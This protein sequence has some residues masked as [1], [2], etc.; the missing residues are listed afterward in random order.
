VKPSISM[1]NIGFNIYYW[2]QKE[3][4]HLLKNGLA[5]WAD[6]ASRRGLLQRLWYCPFDARSPHVFAIFAAPHARRD[7][8]KSFLEDR[9]RKFIDRTPSRVDLPEQE[10]SERHRR[11]RGVTMNCADREPGPALNNSF[12]IF[13][14]GPA[15]YPFWLNK[16]VGNAAELWEHLHLV[17][18]WCLQRA[19][20]D[21]SRAAIQWLA[22]VDRSL[23]RHQV[24][25]VDYWRYHAGSL[26]LGLE[27]SLKKQ[28]TFAGEFLQRA[29]SEKNRQVFSTTWNESDNDPPLDVDALIRLVF[30]QPDSTPDQKF[31]VLRSINHF[32]LLQLG[33]IVLHEIPIVLYAWQRNL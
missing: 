22:A 31:A 28:Q 10:V 29:V 32:T 26:L 8:L 5:L 15:D 12:T 18:S 33:Q 25:R 11:C 14:H 30:S 13:E 27:E 24:P 9:I 6:E 4:Q 19:G 17:S 16:R 21:V 2:G 3:Q 7:A 23:A 20:G 1:A